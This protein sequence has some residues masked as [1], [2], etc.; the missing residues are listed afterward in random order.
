MKRLT[1]VL[2][3]IIIIAA[4]ISFIF[5]AQT[6]KSKPKEKNMPEN[7]LKGKKAVMLVAFR[8]FRDPEY[9]IPKTILEKAGFE[10]KTASN[11]SG[12]AL[13][14]EGGE[15]KI[16]LLLK[17]VVVDDFDA[18]IF[19]GGP[20]CLEH[21]DNEE[22]YRIAKEAMSKNKIL[23]SICISPII[24]AKAGVLKGKRATVWSSSLY[25]KPILDLKNNGAIYE[26]GPVVIDG[27]IITANGPKAAEEFGKTIINLVKKK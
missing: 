17:E 5:I 2:L 12:I 8:D 19:V 24:L 4:I 26:K 22:S 9:F 20:G 13:G 25:K 6:K 18:I 23:A 15:A 11:K 27:N 7:L 3:F 21:L 1:A 14:A 16:N 10:T